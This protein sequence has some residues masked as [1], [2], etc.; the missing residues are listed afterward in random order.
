VAE[1]YCVEGHAL[2]WD[3]MTDAER[4]IHELQDEAAQDGRVIAE[5]S[6]VLIRLGMHTIGTHQAPSQY[7]A[8]STQAC[9]FGGCVEELA[10]RRAL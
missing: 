4:T 3:N 10:Q 1:R 7:D 8:E 2:D 6:A 9:T 5:Y